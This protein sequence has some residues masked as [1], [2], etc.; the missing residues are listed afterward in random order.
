MCHGRLVDVQVVM[1]SMMRHNPRA[2]VV[3]RNT[4]KAHRD[5]DRVAIAQQLQ[6]RI[7]TNANQRVRS[8][9]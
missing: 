3:T 9:P 8:M 4:P 2:E 1:M 7:D 6:Q 5:M